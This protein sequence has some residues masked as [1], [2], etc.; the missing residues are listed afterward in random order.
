[1]NDEGE[2]GDGWTM[3]TRNAKVKVKALWMAR[4]GTQAK[5]LFLVEK[6]TQ[7]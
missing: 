7:D 4:Q 1:V 2:N 3:M 6:S 5:N